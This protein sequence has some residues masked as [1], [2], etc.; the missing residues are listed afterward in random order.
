MKRHE[1]REGEIPDKREGMIIKKEDGGTKN[2]YKMMKW[3]SNRSSG[4]SPPVVELE[5]PD[6]PPTG[7]MA[8]ETNSGVM[9]NIEFEDA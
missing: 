5:Y 4:E 9:K 8:F 7:V 6:I 3:G 2:K 1:R